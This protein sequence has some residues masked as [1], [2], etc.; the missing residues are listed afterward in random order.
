MEGAKGEHTEV[1]KRGELDANHNL[2]DGRGA[3][4]R[5]SHS[6]RHNLII[7][8]VP[9]GEAALW[10]SWPRVFNASRATKSAGVAD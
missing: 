1:R 5:P 6:E 10:S 7:G 8:C 3:V 9:P 2:N 4:V